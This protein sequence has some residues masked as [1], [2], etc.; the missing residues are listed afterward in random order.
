MKSK[1]IPWK[2]L[3]LFCLGLALG[4]S[5]A[6]KWIEP[7]LV[8]NSQPFSIIGLELSY[9]REKIIEIFTGIDS[10]IKTILGYHLYFDFIFMA[11]IY[12]G[13]ASLCMI[14]SGKINSRPVKIILFSLAFLQLAGWAFDIIE[15]YYL[16]KWLKQ[17]VIGNE[18]GF[19]HMVVY[20]KW[21]IALTGAL[22]ALGIITVSLFKKKH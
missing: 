22:F 2:S 12:P 5:F 4:G 7:D 14:A 16:L 17:P 19:F 13:I 6:M 1:S 18:F 3:F 20:T 11:G 15:N 8:F 21:A 10:R 9:A